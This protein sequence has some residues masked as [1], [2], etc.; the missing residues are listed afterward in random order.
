MVTESTFDHDP[1]VQRTLSIVD[2]QRRH[3][4]S[5]IPSVGGFSQAPAP[6]AGSDGEGDQDDEEGVD[7]NVGAAGAGDTGCTGANIRHGGA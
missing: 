7:A 2:N 6:E 3:D 1:E 4:E 5:V